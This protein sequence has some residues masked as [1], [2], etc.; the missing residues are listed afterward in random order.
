MSC[1]MPSSR[2]I[3]MLRSSLLS[4]A[5]APSTALSTTCEQLG[6]LTMAVR[7]LT[8]ICS[9]MR[10]LTLSEL[11]ASTIRQPAHFC[12]TSSLCEFCSCS[13]SASTPCS[14]I[15][16]A[17]ALSC[18]EMFHTAEAA[19]ATTAGERCAPRISVLCSSCTSGRTAPSLTMRSRRSGEVRQFLRSTQKARVRSSVLVSRCGSSERT[20]PSLTMLSLAAALPDERLISALATASSSTSWSERSSSISG[21]STCEDMSFSRWNSTCEMSATWLQS[22]TSSSVPVS[23]KGRLSISE[24]K[25]MYFGGI[26]SSRVRWMKPRSSST[27]SGRLLQRNA[28]MKSTSVTR[29]PSAALSSS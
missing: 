3:D 26:S 5:S 18:A 24:R 1:S 28:A 13:V 17:F 14:L 9:P 10:F 12:Q 7:A 2:I 16:S 25:V 22:A 8:P 20:P 15:T 19:A 27:R 6:C 4:T 23:S 11:A 21:R 29:S